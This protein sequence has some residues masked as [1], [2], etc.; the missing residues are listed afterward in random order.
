MLMLKKTPA[1]ATTSLEMPGKGGPKELV[2][3]RR[4]FVRNG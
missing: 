2:D 1:A 3:L 4:P